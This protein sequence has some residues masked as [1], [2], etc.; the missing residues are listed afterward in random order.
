MKRRDWTPLFSEYDLRDLLERQLH[1]IG[2]AVLGVPSARFD[3][4]TDEQLS[5]EV[6]S[7]LV[8]EPLAIVDDEISV[9]AQDSKID[10]SQD[11]D[12]AIWD[13][14]VPAYVDGKEVTYHVPVTGNVELLRRRPSKYTTSVP[15]P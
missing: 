4:E 9:A 5:A 8:I 1:Q 15:V 14:S 7:A 6:A 12:R 3:R 11:F 10:V 13:R 2:A